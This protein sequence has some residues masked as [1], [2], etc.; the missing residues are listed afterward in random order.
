MTGEWNGMLRYCASKMLR[1]GIT[2]FVVLTLNFIIPRVMPGDPM[3]NLLGEDAVR[4]DT[5]ILD[6]LRAQYRLDLPLHEQFAA[7]LSGIG[8]LDFGYSI[9]KNL[10][11]TD[12]LSQRLFPTLL[13]VFP[14]IVL[15]G[16]A[17]LILGTV[18]GFKPGSGIDR[19]ITPVAAFLYTVPAFLL[20]MVMVSLFSFHLG[21][22]PLGS[23]SSG[24]KQGILWWIDI[25][26][27]L[28]LPVIVLSMLEAAYGLIVMRSAVSRIMAEYFILVNRSRGLS[29]RT[30][31]FRHV[32]KNV[33]P[34]F[35][36]TMALNFGFMVGG[37]LIIEIVFSLNGMGTLIYEAVKSLDYPVMQG[38]FAIL[39]LFVLVANFVAD[40]LYGIVD[41]RI[42]DTRRAG[43]KR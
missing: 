13:L 17:A 15:G 2:L 31:G 14:S 26:W 16:L 7:Y 38:A 12:L 11:V 22:F 28:C 41:P 30:I 24:G 27:H 6:N 39:T 43:L 20:A 33:L 19:M 3:I 10:G 9:Q 23:L 36:S 29:G 5:Q 18:C 4:I 32:M 35:I 37:A 34:E 42:A 40:L 1:Y 21:W 25:A 8:R